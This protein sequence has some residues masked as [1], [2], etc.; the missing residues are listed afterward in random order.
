MQALLRYHSDGVTSDNVEPSSLLSL[1]FYIHPLTHPLTLIHRINPTLRLA[2]TRS[3][4][5]LLPRLLLY[6]HFAG[7]TIVNLPQSATP[8]PDPPNQSEVPSSL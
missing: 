2:P 6:P 7:H 8:V 4:T 1:Y 3:L 5:F